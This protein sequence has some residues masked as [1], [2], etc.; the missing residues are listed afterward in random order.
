MRPAA[1]CGRTSRSSGIPHAYGFVYRQIMRG[2]ITPI[3]PAFV[4][5]FYPPNQPPMRRCL[6]FGVA[7]AN[8]IRAWDSPARVA[9]V[10][11]GGLSHFVVDESLDRAVLAA[12]Q[13]RDLNKLAGYDVAL[14][15]D[16]TS[17]VRNWLP[18]AAAMAQTN[19]PMR[20]VDYQPCYRS[21]AG[22]G[23]GLAF[24]AWV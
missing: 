17:E 21:D 23:N 22:T 6:D 2:R 14:F 15:R 4:N 8:A 19:L 18:V 13:S 24:A 3:V 10:A 11:S 5:T 12:M 1:G 7:L 9:V 16:G 20:L